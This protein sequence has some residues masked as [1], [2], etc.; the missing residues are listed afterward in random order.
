MASVIFHVISW[1]AFAVALAVFGFAPGAV[2]RL[3]VLVYR[4][5]NPRRR[6]LPGELYAVP[7]IERPFWVIEQLE[8]ALFEGLRCR[9]ARKV[10]A[11]LAEAGEPVNYYEAIMGELSVAR[12]AGCLANCSLAIVC[13]APGYE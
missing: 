6:E 5:D 4:R 7:R 11:D 1:P 3:I 10:P 12:K 13:R 2:L 9:L 8:V